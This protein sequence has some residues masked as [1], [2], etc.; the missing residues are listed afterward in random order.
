MSLS[1][2][3]RSHLV[4]A[5]QE[6][7]ICHSKSRGLSQNCTAAICIRV[8]EAEGLVNFQGL[9]AGTLQFVSSFKNPSNKL[10]IT[11]QNTSDIGN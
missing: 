2:Y 11:T 9:Q 6:V 4:V 3:F 1:N 10:D 8:P 5:G 7:D